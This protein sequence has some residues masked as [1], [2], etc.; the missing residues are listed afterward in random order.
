MNYKIILLIILLKK[1]IENHEER[2]IDWLIDF[3]DKSIRVHFLF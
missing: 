3:K 1:N 2:F